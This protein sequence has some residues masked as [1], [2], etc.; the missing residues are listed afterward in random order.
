MTGANTASGGTWTGGTLSGTGT[1]TLTGAL[2][3]T[4]TANKLLAGGHTL[5]TQ[6]TTT[7]DDGDLYLQGV[8][9]TFQNEGTFVAA[10]GLND[11]LTFSVAGASFD[12]QGVFRKQG[13]D[14]TTRVTVDFANQGL[15]DVQQGILDLDG[16]YT[17]SGGGSSTRL[18][19]GD[20]TGLA[21]L[22]IQGGV[23]EGSGSITAAVDL[24]A[25]LSP[26]LSGAVGQIDIVGALTFDD[27]AEFDILLEGNTAGVG[28]DFV[29]VV[30]DVLLDGILDVHVDPTFAA[31]LAPGDGFTVLQG[32]RAVAGAFDNVASGGRLGSFDVF[33]GVDLGALGDFT[34]RVALVFVPEPGSAWL[35]GL[36]LVSLARRRRRRVQF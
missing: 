4:G 17:Q 3:F 2:G 8:G 32:D 30:G 9:T 7:W 36:G 19:G 23:V 16:T 27:S 20:I 1:T 14:D 15:V 26:G 12:N 28:F 18:D 13:T 5:V 24:N 25:L 31:T 35:V 21:V 22:D 10:A 33:Y 34:D 6:G 29:S 11:R